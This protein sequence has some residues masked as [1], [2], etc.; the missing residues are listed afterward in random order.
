MAA[1]FPRAA[2]REQDGFTLVELMVVVT[3]LG[4]LAAL[5]LPAFQDYSVRAKMS[6]AILAVS[7]CRSS[8]SEIYQSGSSAPSANSWGCESATPSKY[9]QKIE[10]DANG[11][12]TATVTSIASAVDGSVLTLVPLRAAGTPATVPGDIGSALFGWNCGGSGTTV[13]AKYLP[14][15]CRGS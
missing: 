6:E 5:A 9:V 3:I 10:T 14:A 13:N 1:I 12:V 11:A 7:A 15:S 8:I 2:R 4:I